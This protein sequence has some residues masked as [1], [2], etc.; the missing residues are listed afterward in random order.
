MLKSYS[1]LFLSAL[2]LCCIVFSYEKKFR[3][4]FSDLDE[5]MYSIFLF[6]KKINLIIKN[7]IK[8]HIT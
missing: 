5:L 2:N 1:T 8:Q 6:N 4:I 7:G 3:G